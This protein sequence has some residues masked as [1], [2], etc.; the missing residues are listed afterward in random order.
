VGSTSLP[1]NTWA[2]LTQPTWELDCWASRPAG[3]DVQWAVPMIPGGATVATG[4][5]GAY[6]SYWRTLGTNLVAGDPAVPGSAQPAAILRIGWEFNGSWIPWFMGKT[7]TQQAQFI[8]YFRHIVTA[9]RSVP[10]QKFTIE[11][12]L[13]GGTTGVDARKAYPGDAYVDV[14]GIDDYDGSWFANTYPIPANATPAQ[15]AQRQTTALTGRL[16]Q[17]N[18]GLNAWAKFAAQHHKKVAM[19]EWGLLKRTDTGN[20]GG[21]D[22]PIYIHGIFA[23]ARNLAAKGQL[24]YIDYFNQL[25]SFDSRINTP[26]FKNSAAAYKAEAK[27]SGR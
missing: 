23:W 3:T 9:L 21:G 26:Y 7:A 11:W 1:G 24:S 19:A 13:N 20:H 14:I 8:S 27:Y 18:F 10:G 4:A 2:T 16:N 12:N 15:V 6:D 22:D 17:P 5:T 25:G